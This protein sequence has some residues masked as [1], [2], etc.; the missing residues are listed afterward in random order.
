MVMVWGS[1]QS[2]ISNA[3]W[4]RCPYSLQVSARHA[5]TLEGLTEDC[6]FLAARSVLSLTEKKEALCTKKQAVPEPSAAC[7]HSYFSNENISPLVSWWFQLRLVYQTYP[8][9]EISCR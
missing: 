5:V 8:F 3:A 2:G 7:P 6:M 4:Y 9:P 1:L